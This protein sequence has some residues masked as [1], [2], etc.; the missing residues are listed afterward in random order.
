MQNTNFYTKQKMQTKLLVFFILLL[1]TSF[2]SPLN[3]G[4]EQID[5]CLQCNANQD[6]ES[7]AQCEPNH[8]LFFHNLLCLP[9]DHKIYG[10]VGCRGGCTTPVNFQETRNI[11][12]DEQGCKE[13][14]YNVKG[15]CTKCDF[16]SYFCNK[17]TYLPYGSDIKTFTCTECINDEFK[18]SKDDG[19]CKHCSLPNCQKCHWEDETSVCDK[20][21]G[22]YYVNSQKTCSRCYKVD[23]TGGRCVVCSDNQKA[24]D[25]GYCY[26]YY[27]FALSS[28]ST[29]TYCGSHCTHCNI[30]K[31]TRRPECYRCDPGYTVNE[32]TKKCV[33]C[34]DNCDFCY[35]DQNDEP[36]CRLCKPGFDLNE[37][38]NCFSCQERCASCKKSKNSN[39]LIC[40]RCLHKYGLNPQNQCLDCP[41]NC[42]ICKYRNEQNDFGC[43]DCFYPYIVNKEEQCV[44]C[45]SIQEIGGEGCVR[46]HCSY[47]RYRQR[48]ECYL[49]QGHEWPYDYNTKYAFIRNTYQCLDNESSDQKLKTLKGCYTAFYNEFKQRYECDRCKNGYIPV[50]NEKICKKPSDIGLTYCSAAKNIGTVASPLYSCINCYSYYYPASFRYFSYTRYKNTKNVV[51][52]LEPKD[53]LTYCLDAIENDQGNKQCIRCVSDFQFIDSETYNRKVCDS[54]CDSE[55]F[56]KWSYCHKCNDRIFG[57]RGCVLSKGCDYYPANDQLNC[58]ECLPGYFLYTYGQC[59]SCS[60]YS[61]ACSECSYDSTNKKMIC[62]KCREG[63]MVENDKCVLITCD[64]YPEITPGCIICKDKLNDFKPYKKCQSCKENFFKTKD[65]SCVYCKAYKNGGPSCEE[66]EYATDDKGIETNQLK[67]SYCPS[68]NVLSSDGKCLN[69]QDELGKNCKNCRF[70]TNDD[71]STETLQCVECDDGFNLN[72][73]GHCISHKSYVKY[74]PYCSDIKYEV[75]NNKTIYSQNSTSNDSSSDDNSTAFTV[76]TTCKLCKSGYYKDSNGDCIG[77]SVDTC[78][79]ISLLNSNGSIQLYN[80]CQNFCKGREYASIDYSFDFLNN[81]DINS[82]DYSIEFVLNNFTYINELLEKIDP[83]FKTF[84]YEGHLCLKNTGK[85]TK[86]EPKSLKKCTHTSYR[87]E[88]NAYD[89]SECSSGYSLNEETGLCEQNVKVGINLRPGFS[90]CPVE[91]IGTVNDPIYSCKYCY[92][93]ENMIEVKVESGAIFC[94]NK[95]SNTKITGCTEIFANTTYLENVYNCTECEL[96]YIS[97]NNRYQQRKTCEAAFG[98]TL[99]RKFSLSEDAF[100]DEDLEFVE[101]VDGKCERKYFTPDG[102]KCYQCSDRKVGMVGCKKTCQFN[103]KRNT[104]LECETDGCK[105]GYLELSKGK[106]KPCD[107]VNEGCIECHYDNQYLS[108]Y[109]GLKRQRRFVCDVCDEGYL[110]STDGTCHHCKEIGFTNCKKCKYDED[111]DNDLVCAE[112]EEGYFVD[113]EG[114]CTKCQSPQVRGNSKQCINCNDVEDGGIEGCS[115]CASDGQKITCTICEE[116]FIL[117]ENNKTCLRISEYADLENFI[118]CKEVALDENSKFYCSI[119]DPKYVLLNENNEIKCTRKDFLL[120]HDHSNGVYDNTCKE[121]KNLGTEDK[122][123]YTCTN[124]ITPEPYERTKDVKLTKIT[125]T[126]NNTAYCEYSSYFSELRNCSEAISTTINKKT[127]LNCTACIENN[128]LV[129]DRDTKLNICRYV[130]K[131]CMVKFCRQCERDD[132]YFCAECTASDYEVNPVTGSCVLKTQKAPAVTWKDIFR[133]QMNSNRTLRN[134]RSLYGPSMR[135]RGITSS[136]INTGHAFLVN[137]IFQVQVTR[138]NRRLVE[139]KSI[140]TFCEVIDSVDESEDDFNIVEYDCIANMT[141]DNEPIPESNTKLQNIEENSDT[142]VIGK[143]NFETVVKEVA[144]TSI[145]ELK[146][147]TKPNYKVSNFANTATFSITN[148]ENKTSENYYFKFT[149]DG[150]LNKKVSATSVSVNMG[151]AEINENASCT[152]DINDDESAKLNCE[153]D[154]KNYKDVRNVTF[155]TFELTEVSPPVYLARIN[156]IV[157]FND[158]PEPP[159]NT[160]SDF[161]KKLKIILIIIAVVIVVIIAVSIVIYYL[162]KSFKKSKKKNEVGAAKECVVPFEKNIMTNDL[163]M[164]NNRITN[165]INGTESVV[166]RMKSIENRPKV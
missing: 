151:L 94:L 24:Y 113:V 23:I 35:L 152:F 42:R 85:G 59:L 156:E 46:N 92:D 96:G 16:S 162:L 37:D 78:S 144:N 134:G 132:N 60:V 138:N 34:G 6:E 102:E 123:R 45:Q 27:N 8:F 25:T 99:E 150:K 67:C 133:L 82:S 39:Q 32:K 20:C 48:Y 36:V 43:K 73:N 50:V 166:D 84:I 15:I 4:E 18:V 127:I 75:K 7:C 3:C 117:L 164:G 145:T 54:K 104:V 115:Y 30:N 21:W 157:L 19:R 122:P 108:G 149:I 26:C 72:S 13:T 103:L 148:K 1:S 129:Y 118:N 121:S 136:Q 47:N 93:K 140:P 105:T 70:M 77:L 44:K 52:C 66:C 120:L 158:I 63:Y 22:G 80:E 31:I 109:Y 98:T 135:M 128:T 163:Q 119:C 107:E 74:I 131:T 83:S 62:S 137:M 159:D 142:S 41:S 154:M 125:F 155:N 14:H 89:C 69:C 97:Y 124:C 61:P 90:N 79:F 38:N 10:N 86:L 153:L 91:N 76:I 29:C 17:C 114:K 139:S 64:E 55:S 5:N 56:F 65:E 165:T 33:T 112:C 2:I 9:C 51:N 160:Y 143:T 100:K 95:T 28:H 141:K 58:N 111:L 161:M 126:E 130:D 110:L 116:G 57:N 68:G 81:Y 53:E 40:T 71:N 88:D 101:A 87:E 146:T 12:C 147:K 49:C 106:C 11:N